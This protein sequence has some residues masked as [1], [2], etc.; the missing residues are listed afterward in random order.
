MT[1][2]TVVF[3]AFAKKTPSVAKNSALKFTT[4]VS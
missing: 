2:T 1:F 4:V 3:L